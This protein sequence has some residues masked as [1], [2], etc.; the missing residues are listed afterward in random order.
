[1]YPKKTVTRNKISINK[2][3]PVKMF[4]LLIAPKYIDI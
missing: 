1:M 2:L 3:A 4:P